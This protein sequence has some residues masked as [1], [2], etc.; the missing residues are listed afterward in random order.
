[1]DVGFWVAVIFHFTIIRE[2][3]QQLS[4]W[5]GWLAVHAMI[6]D[7][8]VVNFI[9]VFW[10]FLSSLFFVVVAVVCL[11]FSSITLHPTHFWAV[12]FSLMS[13]PQP[14]QGVEFVAAMFPT[15]W[16]I[17]AYFWVSGCHVVCEEER[18]LLGAF[19]KM[20]AKFLLWDFHYLYANVC[21][22]GC[23]AYTSLTLPSGQCVGIEFGKI[24]RDNT[25]F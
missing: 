25:C 23:L 18:E 17:S 10:C 1:M 6:P 13:H 7:C 14:F 12:G 16:C 9:T 8:S 19:V 4:G 2:C 21:F 11:F 20:N 22:R 24:W 3:L 15:L 5:K